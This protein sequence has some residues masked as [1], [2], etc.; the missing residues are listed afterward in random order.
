MHTLMVRSVFVALLATP[1]NISSCTRGLLFV[2]R[3]LDSNFL[4]L[5]TMN[6]MCFSFWLALG[7]GVAHDFLSPS[8]WYNRTHATHAATPWLSLLL[9]ATIMWI[10]GRRKLKR[11]YAISLFICRIRTSESNAKVWRTADACHTHVP[12]ADFVTLQPG[13]NRNSTERASTT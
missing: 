2:A 5:A 1:F 9:L 6:L 12:T 4:A 3:L 11:T 13:T 10:G 8:S 7:C